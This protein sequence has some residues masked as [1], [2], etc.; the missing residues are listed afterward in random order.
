MQSKKK[1]YEM[2]FKWKMIY[3]ESNEISM[4]RCKWESSNNQTLIENQRKQMRK[5]NEMKWSECV[6]KVQLLFNTYLII[7][8]IIF[9]TTEKK[10]SLTNRKM[11]ESNNE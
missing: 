5:M 2:K 4:R 1:K 3:L 10:S 8:I 6:I 11:D 7:V 9:V